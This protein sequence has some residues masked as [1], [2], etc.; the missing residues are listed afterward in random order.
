VGGARRG[1]GL[2]PK[3]AVGLVARREL[4]RQLVREIVRHPDAG[5]EVRSLPQKPGASSLFPAQSAV[6]SGFENAWASD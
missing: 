4:E 5:E 3:G 2:S 6:P 1:L